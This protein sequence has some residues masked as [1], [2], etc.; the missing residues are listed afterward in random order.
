MSAQVKFSATKLINSGKKGEIKPDANGYYDLI[1]GGLNTLNTA[2]EYYT[3]DGA[4][5]LFTDSSVFMRRVKSGNLRG[6]VGHPKK[7][8]SMTNDD[9]LNRVLS[10]DEGN[11]CAHFSEVWLD[12]DFG[13]KYPALNNKELV[14]V[15]AKVKPSGAKAHA[16]KTSLENINENVCFSIRALTKDYYHRGK[17]FR[18]LTSIFTYDMVNEPGISIANKWDSPSLETLTESYVSYKD[19]EKIANDRT[20]SVATESSRAIAL[21]ALSSYSISELPKIQI[22]SYLNWK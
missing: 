5:E 17:T 6:E 22:P 1:I 11:V 18:V 2:G 12:T 14:A 20:L 8:P 15:M 10:I 16:L 3:L 9:Y 7:Q 21:E 19:L 13:K 4:K